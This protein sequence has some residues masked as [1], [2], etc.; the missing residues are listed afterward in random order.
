MGMLLRRHEETRRA[1]EAAAAEKLRL[2]R[3]FFP[4]DVPFDGAAFGTAVT[5]P[6]LNYLQ[7]VSGEKSHLA[8]PSR[9]EPP[10]DLPD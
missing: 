8:S 6:V 10:A 4:E 9:S 1:A 3:V 5:S 2:Q 7:E